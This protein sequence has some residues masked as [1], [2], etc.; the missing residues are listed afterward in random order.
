MSLR[1]SLGQVRPLPVQ[2]ASRAL[3][4]EPSVTTTH[5]ILENDRV[6][7]GALAKHA[8]FFPVLDLLWAPHGWR[9]IIYHQ[10]YTRMSDVHF[11][12]NFLEYAFLRPEFGLAG[13][14][15]RE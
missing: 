7:S 6:M 11:L 8:M 3:L 12:L 14:F 2:H 15:D 13:A 9:Y 1:H 5:V 4:D 10:L